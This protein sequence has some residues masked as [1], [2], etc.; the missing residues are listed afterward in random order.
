MSL[1]CCAH[2]LCEQVEVLAL[3]AFALSSYA[4]AYAV[5]L[6]YEASALA[7]LDAVHEA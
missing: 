6:H 3:V 2:C 1:C 5:K 4:S 7:A